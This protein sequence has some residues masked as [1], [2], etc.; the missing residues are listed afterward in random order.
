MTKE[1][2]ELSAGADVVVL[3]G[4]RPDVHPSH[5]TIDEAVN[6]AVAIGAERSL[7]T[8]MTYMVD[9]EATEAVLPD[10]IRLAYDGL[11]IT[12]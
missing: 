9:H 3:D 10:A 12:L 1:A 8:H 6:A 4:L 11:R 2:R 5:M 7:L